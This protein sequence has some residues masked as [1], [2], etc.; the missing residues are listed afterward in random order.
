MPENLKQVLAQNFKIL[1]KQKNFTIKKFAEE[2]GIAFSYVSDIRYAKANPT[3]E[4][5]ETLCKTLKIEIIEL[6]NLNISNEE[7]KK[8]I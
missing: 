1:M 6:F 8:L 2:S 7:L 5:L 4:I 3:L